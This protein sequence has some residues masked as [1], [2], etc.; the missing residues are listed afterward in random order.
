MKAITKRKGKVTMTLTRGI[1]TVL[2]AATL[3]ALTAHA[4][5]IGVPFTAPADGTYTVVIDDAATGRTV[6][7]LVT[8]EQMRSGQRVEEWD[9]LDDQGQPVP[10]GEYRF[11]GLY[12]GGIGLNYLM[13]LNNPGTPPWQ[14]DAG[15]GEWGGDH[16]PPVAIAADD[17]GVYFGW[18]D[19]E[20]GNGIIGCTLEGRKSWGVF[21]ADGRSQ[22]LAVDG[23]NL[24]VGTGDTIAC[25]DKKTGFRQGFSVAKGFV[26]IPRGSVAA[27]PTKGGREWDLWQAKQLSLE[28][29]SNRDDYH[30][31]GNCGGVGGGL[32]GLAARDGKLY[33][34]FL[35]SDEVVVLNAADVTEL[36]RWKVSRPAGLAFASGGDLFAISGT[37]VV[38]ID[39]GDGTATPVVGDGRLD[40]PVD[41]AIGPD[42]AF[43]VSQW[44]AAHCV[45]VFDPKGKPIRTIGTPGG[46]P[47]SGA[48]DPNGMLLP[49]GIDIDAK[50]RLWVA[51]YA[52][53]PRRVSVWDAASGRFIR[54]FIGGTVY[55][56]TEGGLIDP[57]NPARAFSDGVWYEL[58]LAKEGYR[59][60]LTLRQRQSIDDCFAPLDMARGNNS[61]HHQII[62]AANGRRYLVA[63]QYASP[64]V[65]GEL[66]PDYSWQPSV[67]IGFVHRD[68]TVPLDKVGNGRAW[69]AFFAK[70]AG[71]TYIWTDA[72]DDGIPQEEEFQWRKGLPAI[73]AAWGTG[74]VDPE[75]NVFGGMGQVTR[76]AFQG[77][78]ANGIPRYDINDSKT[79]AAHGSEC[80]SVAV[81]SRQWVFTLGAAKRPGGV[82]SLSA[83]AP[84][85]DRRW[86]IPTSDDYRLADA[87]S[88][89]AIL[90][91]VTAGGELGEI[92]GVTQ[93]HGLHVPLIT[94]D[95]LLF[96]KLLRDPAQGGKPGPDMHKGETTQCLSAL[97]DGRVILA[98]GKN[99]HHFLHVTGLDTVR[100]FDG[101]FSVT[102]AQVALA[103]EHLEARQEKTAA[104]APIRIT[105][106]AH[107]LKPAKPTVI[108]GNLDD[109]DWTTAGAIGSGTGAPRAEVALRLGQPDQWGNFQELHIAFKV[110][111]NGPFL[112]TGKDDPTK[113]FLTGDAAD[114]HFCTDPAALPRQAPG[115]GD[116][117]LLFSKLDGNPVAVLYRAQVPNAKNPVGFSSP[118]RTVTIDAVT[119]LKDARVAITDTADGYVVEAAVPIGVVSGGMEGGL[120][121]G[122]LL[123]GDAGIIVGD[124]TGRRVARI[125]R[126]NQNTQIVSDVPTE[127]ALYPD[128]WGILKVDQGTSK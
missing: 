97:H 84:D 102:P 33:V 61:H 96:A 18:K 15:D 5:V 25:L 50:G 43:Y 14:T 120:W 59:P 106:R 77:W 16:S 85:G 40:A 21:G 55:G 118:T 8:M 124:T 109:W 68:M 20:D 113:L 112:N 29:A 110:F 13:T 99:A 98:H 80:D 76:F 48:Y 107:Y 74:A 127:A 95:G 49:R 116:R 125:Y 60:L 6:R 65:I 19:A 54:E 122:R 44:G 1:A 52:N 62:K 30:L 128:Q 103:A 111:K 115:L 11:R 27:R 31:N 81:D 90:G 75:M 35:G 100:R 79:V 41:L 56:A 47:R 32:S 37:G 88:G 42:G 69:P 89:E 53:S 119:V 64:I 117:R 73:A 86:S 87:I 24:Y 83:F 123:P 12:H 82:H 26:R 104:A 121:P 22:I 51:E 2:L 4:G 7:R 36:A 63:V 23:P 108:D 72:N 71:E 3:S 92:I 105:W 126:F 70:H 67:A 114:L 17:A 9:G 28:T 45:A 38:R 101:G 58:D 66:K 46:R 93:W 10:A 34:S 78:G 91:P 39:L 57:A 94:T